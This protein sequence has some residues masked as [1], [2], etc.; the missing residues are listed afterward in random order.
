MRFPLII[1]VLG[2][3][4]KT[5]LCMIPRLSD[6][7]TN[8]WKVH[9]IKNFTKNFSTIEKI[10]WWSVGIMSSRKTY[11]SMIAKISLFINC[12]ISL[13]RA[14][15]SVVPKLSN[16]FLASI[17]RLS[18]VEVKIQSRWLV[19]QKRTFQLTF[20]RRIKIGI[21]FNNLRTLVHGNFFESIKELGWKQ[22]KTVKNSTGRYETILHDENGKQRSAYD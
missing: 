9:R 2:S 1:M 10:T 19:T 8:W 14:S 16:T 22:G 20:I 17:R 6:N 21:R 13:Y 4:Q 3:L 18:P 5:I 15:K 11:P 12:P 7:L